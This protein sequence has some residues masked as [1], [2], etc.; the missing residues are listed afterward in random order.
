MALLNYYDTRLSDVYLCYGNATHFVQ[1]ASR[2][3][4]AVCADGRRN[5]LGR[6]HWAT[7][8]KGD[9]DVG[10]TRRR[11]PAEMCAAKRQINRWAFYRQ[12]DAPHPIH[13]TRSNANTARDV[14]KTEIPP[15]K[16]KRFTHGAGGEF[17]NELV[18][19]PQHDG[20]GWGA[21]TDDFC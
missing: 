6:R 4:K 2:L 10:P 19:C 1:Y 7:W 17:P 12:D 3:R 13:E 11:G 18:S 5:P 8:R 9:A 14:T 21:L 15:K 16:F 20:A